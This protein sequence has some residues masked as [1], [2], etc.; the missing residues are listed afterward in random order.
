MDAKHQLQI[1]RKKLLLDKFKAELQFY[2]E[3]DCDWTVDK[4]KELKD[5]IIEIDN[6]MK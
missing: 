6:S 3:D 1:L 5:K 2:E 4:I